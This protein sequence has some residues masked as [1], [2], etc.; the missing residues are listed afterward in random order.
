MYARRIRLYF[1]YCDESM[2]T[3]QVGRRLERGGGGGTGPWCPPLSPGS[4]PAGSLEQ[5]RTLTNLI[6]IICFLLVGLF[7][8][9]VCCDLHIDNKIMPLKLIT[10]VCDRATGSI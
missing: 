4:A 1:A 8:F 2:D 3:I 7:V 9:T 10:R 6:I 5:S